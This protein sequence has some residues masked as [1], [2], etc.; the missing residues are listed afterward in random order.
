MNGRSQGGGGGRATCIADI[1][2]CFLLDHSS[3]ELLEV[4]P[5]VSYEI[6]KLE[7]AAMSS[8]ERGAVSF[9]E[10]AAAAAEGMIARGIAAA[11][12]DDDEAEEEDEDAD[13]C[14]A[15][16]GGASAATL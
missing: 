1:I 3:I 11:K 14:S 6:V 10:E 8:G 9:E 16:G 15:S 13:G 2:F 4:L 5:R 7:M 12:V